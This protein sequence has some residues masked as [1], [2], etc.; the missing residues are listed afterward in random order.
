MKFAGGTKPFHVVI[1]QANTSKLQAVRLG[2]YLAH[3][4]QCDLM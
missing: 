4:V 3:E 1:C 2:R